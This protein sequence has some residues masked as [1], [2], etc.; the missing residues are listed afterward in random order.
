MKRHSILNLSAIAALALAVV[1]DGA[2]AQQK[3][4]KEQLVG[5]W[6]FV[7]STGKL[8]DGNSPWGTNPKGQLSFDANGRYSSIIVRS[9]LAKYA[10]N[11]R[12]Q[13]SPAEAI[14][15]VQGAIAYFGTYTMNE[16]DRSYTVRVDVSSYP[17]W[18]GTDLK[19]VVESITADELKIRNPAPSY[20][21]PPTLL[22][23]RRGK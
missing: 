6:A 21:G 1:P 9:D 11:N 20:G 23:Y 16:A 12:T 7:S 17:N 5:T 14:A 18:N 8:A 15:T 3:S 10:S 2:A 22:T 13:P 4:L 19:Q